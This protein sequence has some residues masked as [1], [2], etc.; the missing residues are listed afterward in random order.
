MFIVKRAADLQKITENQGHIGFVPT[1]GALH[2]GH[3]SLI[4]KSRDASQL[5]VCSIFVNPTQFN[6]PQDF[7]KYP[8]TLEND[9][10]LLEKAGCDVLF[11]PEVS[12]MYPEGILNIRQYPIGY[13]DTILEG[14]HRPGHFN[15]VCA[16]V[17]KLLQT[18]NPNLL[19]LGEKD[20]QQCLVI[21]QLVQN[22]SIPVEVQICPT[23]RLP[24]G[25]A[26]SS[27]NQRLSESG[28]EL[29]SA[30]YRNLKK[31]QANWQNE[32]FSILR[33]QALNALQEASF[34]TE[35]LE[36]ADANNLHPLSDFDASKLMVVLIATR[37][38][39][40]RLIDNIKIPLS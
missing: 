36:L 37:L 14:L 20:F 31:I 5:T 23:T 4:E 19:Y 40:I 13:L 18:V 9:I 30:I 26:M 17:H 8:K 28:K 3:I 6:D 7:I 38:E 10:Y 33:Q 27:R 16:I 29:A 11:L 12:E 39:G 1:M 15:G 25:L 21:Q 32:S 24:N 2:R 22:E 35:Y 34:E